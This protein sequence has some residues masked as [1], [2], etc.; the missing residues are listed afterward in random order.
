MDYHHYDF[1]GNLGVIMILG[2]YLLVQVGRMSANSYAYTALNGLGAAFIL[3]SLLFDFNMSAFIIEICWVLI[4]L[5]GMLR[6]YLDPSKRRSTL[7]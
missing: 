5:V 6:L 4:S 2:S 3:Y 1:V 7:T